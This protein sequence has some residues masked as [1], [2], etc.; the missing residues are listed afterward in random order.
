[1][2]VES[3]LRFFL[4]RRKQ[5]TPVHF[6]LEGRDRKRAHGP[7]KEVLSTRA[8]P[9]FPPELETYHPH[10]HLGPQQGS[11]HLLA[12]MGMEPGSEP[13]GLGMTSGLQGSKPGGSK[14]RLCLQLVG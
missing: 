12:P 3:S 6:V 11:P 2:G 10:P 8:Q 14:E 4:R 5:R 13:Q 9:G 1:M 7:R